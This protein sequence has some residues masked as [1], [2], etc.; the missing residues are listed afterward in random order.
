MLQGQRAL[1]ECRVLQEP[2]ARLVLGQLAQQ[3][4]QEQPASR[5]RLALVQL[6]QP[7]YKALQESRARPA[8]RPS[9][10]NFSRQV[11]RGQN[12][13]M[14]VLSTSLSSLQAEEVEE[15]VVMQPEP[16]DVEVAV[17]AVVEPDGVAIR[18]DSWARQK[19]SRSERAARLVLLQRVTLRM[20]ETAALAGA[21][22]SRR[23][24]LYS[25]LLVVVAQAK[26]ERPRQVLPAL[27]AA[28]PQV[29]K[30]G[31]VPQEKSV[32]QLRLQAWLVPPE[33]LV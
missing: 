18:L 6:E 31:V 16:F 10:C 23:R 24:P 9:M 8:S 28:S 13:R 5:A 25:S 11:G 17:E 3:E 12:Q 32:Q 22:H 26:V 33:Q 4:L 14:L 20:V 19:Q 27:R 7:V 29:S 21:P 15:D 2:R 1:V 30:L